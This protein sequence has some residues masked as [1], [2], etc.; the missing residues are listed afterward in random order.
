M[1]LD[2]QVRP[3]PVGVTA[4]ETPLGFWGSYKAARRNVLEL[5]PAAAY[6]ERAI[7]DKK[8][9]R[10][11]M[12]MDPPSIDK[13]LRT[14]VE[15]YP[16]SAILIRLMTP[17]EGTNLIITEGEIWRRQR[18]ALSAPF[19]PRAMQVAGPIMCKAA[20]DAV[21]TL[22]ET[23]GPADVF[24]I[25]AAASCD[26]MVDLALGGRDAIDRAALA[27]AVE[28]YVAGLGRV[29]FFDILGV[30]NW[31]PRPAALFEGSRK[32]M[33]DIGDAVIDARKSRGPSAAPDLLDLLIEA[34]QQGTLDALEVRNNLLGFLFAGHETTALSLTWALY[35]LALHPEAQEKARR[36]VEDVC[37]GRAPT[38]DDVAGLTFVRQVLD[39]TLRLYPP[40]GFLT[41]TARADDQL[42]GHDV[43]AGSTVILPIYA[44]HRHALHWSSPEMFL[45]E[46]FAPDAEQKHHR[47]AYLPFSDGPRICIG[48]AM[49]LTE[50]T[51]ILAT[52][53]KSVCF[54][55]PD[56]YE[57]EPVMWFTL[58]PKD[59]M[60]LI[61]TPIM[62]EGRHRSEPV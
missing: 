9:G 2:S 12:L 1:A 16:K 45:P 8:R 35:L 36:E 23:S 40:A 14:Q 32:R 18:R 31:V 22:K 43:K 13:V 21:A 39:E 46:R 15:N 27:E 6:R 60:R 44:L 33:D 51:L 20:A 30:P 38:I 48:A 57:P 4:P 49:A 42:A 37:A 50:A 25:M 34:H 54:S 29:S 11:I 5:I 7:L 62:P 59:G 41:R 47:S 58:R 24:P 10:W 52:L 3:Q 28:D 55:L 26:V 19:Q 61:A 53:L 56:G 17:R